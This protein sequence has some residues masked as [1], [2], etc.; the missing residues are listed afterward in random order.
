MRPHLSNDQQSRERA[1]LIM[2][3][4]SHPHPALLSDVFRSFRSNR[5]VVDVAVVFANEIDDVVLRSFGDGP[6]YTLA[7]EM[8]CPDRLLDPAVVAGANTV[9][10]YVHSLDRDG[11]TTA[12]QQMRPRVMMNVLLVLAHS[13]LELRAHSVG[14]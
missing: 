10:S 13:V 14:P 9:F 7:W 2:S 8:L 1:E 6:V 11:V 3:A 4:L 5:E 12:V